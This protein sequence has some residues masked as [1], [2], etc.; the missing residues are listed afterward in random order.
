MH[1]RGQADVEAAIVGPTAGVE[2]TGPP[3]RPPR[4]ARRTFTLSDGH[5]V[6]LA[7]AGRGFPLVVV[8]GFSAEGLLYAQTLSRLVDMRFKVIAVDIAGHGG[9]QGLP[10]GG[11]NLDTYAELVARTLAE[12]GIRKAVLVGHS[13]GGRLVTTVAANQPE[14]SIA[15]IL[16]DAVVGDTWDRMVDVSRFFPPLLAGV[17][18]ILVVDTLSTVPVFR[19]PQQAAKLGRLVAPT[20]LGHLRRPWRMVGPAV[21]ILRSRGSRWMLQRIAEERIPLVAVNGQYDFV[22]PV[23]T[24]RSAAERARGELVVVKGATHSWLLKDPETLPAVVHELMKGRL[25][26]ALLKSLLRAGV[27]PNGATDD[28]IEA[29]LYEPDAPVLAMT[30]ALDRVDVG[31]RHRH[32]RYKF[33][34]ER[35]DREA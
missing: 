20:L 6:G 19:D 4:L 3:V 25:G 11:A 15:V 1:A 26:T 21:S 14:R 16:L 13:L 33:D 29:V 23:S 35:R 24:A 34:F 30:P 7:V 17:A 18:V 31:A 27:D 12:L 10:T 2:G 32:P 28:E 8:H 22:V 5:Q 9:T